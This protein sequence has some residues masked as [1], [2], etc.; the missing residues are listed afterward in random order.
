MTTH[1]PTPTTAV[2]HQRRIG[3][4]VIVAL[5]LLLSLLA[6]APT[7]SATG[8]K[9]DNVSQDN[10]VDAKVEASDDEAGF[11]APDFVPG[12]TTGTWIPTCPIGALGVPGGCYVFVDRE[13]SGQCPSGSYDAGEKQCRKPVA[14]SSRPGSFVWGG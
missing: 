7:A 12:P 5:S 13:R 8:D 4:L 11:V 6:I 1:S 10:V 14:D 2:P 3:A 9:H